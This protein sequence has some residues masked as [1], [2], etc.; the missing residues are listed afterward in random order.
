MVTINYVKIKPELCRDCKYRMEVSSYSAGMCGY[1]LTTG[2]SRVFEKGKRRDIPAGY[3]DKYAE[4]RPGDG[5]RIQ[6]FSLS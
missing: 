1:I 2:H 5:S 3:C 4:R 6:A